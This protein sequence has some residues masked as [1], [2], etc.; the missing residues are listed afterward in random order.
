MKSILQ[1]LRGL[2]DIAVSIIPPHIDLLLPKQ[3]PPLTDNSNDQPQPVHLHFI[4]SKSSV[5][6][7]GCCCVKVKHFQAL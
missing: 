1:S 6:N 5:M 7:N 2:C 4:M 3:S